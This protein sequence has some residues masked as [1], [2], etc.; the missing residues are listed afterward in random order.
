MQPEAAGG[1][2]TWLSYALHVKPYPWMPVRLI[3][4]R[5]ESEIASNLQAVQ[6]YSDRLWAAQT[7]EVGV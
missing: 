7:A 2:G 6:A 3:Q 5:I 4:G 1:A